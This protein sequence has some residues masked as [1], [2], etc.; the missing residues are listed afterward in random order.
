MILA[1]FSIR[2][3]LVSF[4][5]ISFRFRF[6][7]GIRRSRRAALP[8]CGDLRCPLLG[9]G[10][11]KRSKSPTAMRPSPGSP[12]SRI[13]RIWL[14]EP[15]DIGIHLAFGQAVE[16]LFLR[17][18]LFLVRFVLERKRVTFTGYFELYCLLLGHVACFPLNEISSVVIVCLAYLP[19]SS[20]PIR[21]GLLSRVMHLSTSRIKRLTRAIALLWS[22]AFPASPWLS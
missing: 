21:S 19:D 8:A 3:P 15:G 4:P 16:L 17:Q 6:G 14:F 10:P 1:D 2:S 12:V 5:V 11:A 7:S 18:R 13:L 9:C 20:S 22:G